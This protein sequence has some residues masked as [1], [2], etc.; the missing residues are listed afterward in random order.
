ML[1]AWVASGAIGLAMVRTGRMPGSAD[2]RGELFAD[3]IEN[4]TTDPADE[5][6]RRELAMVGLLVDAG[7][8]AR[9]DPAARD[10]M[11]ERIMAGLAAEE[12]APTQ[13]VTGAPARAGTPASTAVVRLADRRRGRAV[14]GGVQGRLLVAAAASL[15]LLAALSAMSLVLSRDALP[16]DALYGFKRSAE[17]AELG[18]TFGNEPRGFKHLQFATAR[19]DEIEALAA[20]AGGSGSGGNAGSFVTALQAFDTDAAAGSRLLIETATNSG[21]GE[22]AVLR[23]WAEQQQLR[24]DDAGSVMPDRALSRA[25]GSL[26]LLARVAARAAALQARLP[27]LTVTSGARDEIGLVPADGR[28]VAAPSVEPG[29]SDP[30]STVRPGSTRE[31]E[32]SAAGVPGSTGTE[33]PG[34]S[35]SSD[36][37]PELSSPP[38]EPSPE[39]QPGQPP[40]GAGSTIT[41][42]LPLPG[43]GI[44]I[45]PLL[46]GLP[47]LRLG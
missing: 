34:P 14:T 42:P 26:D 13:D 29:Q 30:T 43:P 40:S 27:C 5:Q 7:R 21:G 2:R 46:P 33:D 6:L 38:A 8:L 37:T 1:R 28:C 31:P 15:C 3:A 12:F 25:N 39:P 23:G 18:L 9:P 44:T 20:R 22:L 24:L 41:V 17:S 16:G 36:P 10:R 19:V 45:P 4:G 35:G 47:S 32:P 11:R